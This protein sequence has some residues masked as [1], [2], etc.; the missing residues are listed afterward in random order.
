MIRLP[1]TTFAKLP[2]RKL[3]S[4]STTVD[5]K[6]IDYAMAERAKRVLTLAALF[7]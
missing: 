4:A 6:M 1:L 2:R 7:E 5:G 3:A